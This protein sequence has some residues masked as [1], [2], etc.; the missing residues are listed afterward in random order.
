MA[1]YLILFELPLP[2]RGVDYRDLGNTSTKK[3][4]KTAK[5]YLQNSLEKHSSNVYGIVIKQMWYLAYGKET[6]H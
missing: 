2:S 3:K 4:H 6:K 5:R 1:P